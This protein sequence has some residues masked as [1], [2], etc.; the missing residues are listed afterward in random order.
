MIIH[1]CTHTTNTDQDHDTKQLNLLELP[2]ITDRNCDGQLKT[3][4]PIYI[5]HT[6]KKV[7]ILVAG[8]RRSDPKTTRNVHERRKKVKNDAKIQGKCHPK[9]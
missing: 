5:Y 1:I 8:Y 2:L 4:L 9:K 3:L 6:W 7:G